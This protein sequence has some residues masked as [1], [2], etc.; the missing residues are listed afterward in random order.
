LYSSFGVRFLFLISHPIGRG[1]FQ[2]L[3]GYTIYT[4]AVRAGRVVVTH[5]FCLHE[6]QGGVDGF[7]TNGK[8]FMAM[9]ATDLHFLPPVSELF[10]N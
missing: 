6:I 10:G 1:S 8:G 3:A 2:C 7:F 9:V 4:P 5:V